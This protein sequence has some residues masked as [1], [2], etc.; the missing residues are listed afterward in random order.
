MVEEL[1]NQMILEL[2][3]SGY[4]PN[5]HGSMGIGL[6]RRSTME[7]GSRYFLNQLTDGQLQLLHKD[8]FRR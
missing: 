6:F 1:R 4:E 7:K 5:I 8:F 3:I 2:L